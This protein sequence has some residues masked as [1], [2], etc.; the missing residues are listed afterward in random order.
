MNSKERIQA[1]MSYH[2]FLLLAH[3]WFDKMIIE[4]DTTE[5]QSG[6]SHDKG[7]STWKALAKIGGLC[8]RAEFKEGQEDLPILRYYFY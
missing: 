4:A 3:M 1:Y 7:S 5:D 2:P 8:N 6:L